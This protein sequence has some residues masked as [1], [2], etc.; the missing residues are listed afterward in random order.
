MLF[1]LGLAFLTVFLISSAGIQIT[2]EG[3]MLLFSTDAAGLEENL[4]KGIIPE[5]LKKIFNISNETED[6]WAITKEEKIYTIRKENKTLNVSTGFPP[7]ENASIINETDEWAITCKGKI[8]NI[9]KEEEKLNVYGPIIRVRYLIAIILL[10]YVIVLILTLLYIP[11][12]Y[13][14]TKSEVNWHIFFDKLKKAVYISSCIA[15]IA[16]LALIISSAW[17]GLGVALQF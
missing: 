17:Y 9:K 1:P 4:S 8:F 13:F 10:P 6:K 12:N 14:F 7:S 16:L 5:E 2:S 15:A 3:E 11:I